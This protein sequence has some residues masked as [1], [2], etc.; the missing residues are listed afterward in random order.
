[1]SRYKIFLLLIKALLSIFD[2]PI[3]GAYTIHLVTRDLI[4]LM[5]FSEDHKLRGPSLWKSSL[6]SKV[7]N[8]VNSILRDICRTVFR[9]P[10]I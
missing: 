6:P 10:I 8:I 1:M 2:S 7:M 3:R 9:G 4:V 5:T